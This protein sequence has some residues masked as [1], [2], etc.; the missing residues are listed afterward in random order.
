VA[1]AGTLLLLTVLVVG[2]YI[3]AAPLLEDLVAR[4][5]QSQLGLESAP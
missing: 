1:L 2:V 3:F 5:L 4:N